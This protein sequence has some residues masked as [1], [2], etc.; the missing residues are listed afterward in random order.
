MKRVLKLVLVV[1]VLGLIGYG[2]VRTYQQVAARQRGADATD[3]PAALRV[4]V[5]PVVRATLTGTVWVTGEVDALAEVD[6]IPKVTGQLQRLR[7]P[8][9][10]LI[11][12]GACVVKG[13]V[14]AVIEHAALAAS[15]AL[16]QAALDRAKVLALPAVVTAK[17]Q[18]ARAGVA[19]ARAQ[20]A[21]MDAN[22]RNLE[23]EKDR[24]V[25]LHKRGSETEAMRDRAVTAYE[26]AREKRAGMRAQLDRAQAVLALADSQTRKLA[27][28][29]VAQAQAALRQA[30]V[31][32]AE[33]TIQAP[34]TGVVSKRHVDEGDMVGPTQALV[35]LVAIDTV[36]IVGGVSERY[37]GKLVPGKTPAHV[38]VDA[39]EGDTCQGQVYRVGPAVDRATRTVEVEVRVKNAD[40][41]LKPG[42]FGRLRLL[43]DRRDQV[44]VVPD[45]ALLRDGAK[46][47]VYV[48]DSDSRARRRAVRLGLSEGPRHEVVAGVDVGELVVVR[49]QRMLEDGDE[50]VVV[51]EPSR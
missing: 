43:V 4:A 36:K 3:P 31:N 34:I 20:M 37:I 51:R 23:R 44:A 5:Q 47:Y 13:Q 19:G 49:G 15:V 27:D 29:G 6:V 33:A 41:R 17:V 32:L 22:L 45:A 18:E 26:A 42:M 16:A 8:N 25:R 11:E 10:A 1:M 21:E 35:K 2:G 24:A 48:V 30:E 7:L 12:E 50:V 46:V 9:G 38:V 14:I 40:H 28:A 39:C